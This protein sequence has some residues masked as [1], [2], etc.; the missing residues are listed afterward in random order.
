M[1][2]D[3]DNGGGLD[4]GIDS[5][6]VKQQQQRSEEARKEKEESEEGEPVESTEQTESDESEQ[7][8]PSDEDT[9]TTSTDRD[10]GRDTSAT[11]DQDESS[12]ELP[13]VKEREDRIQAYVPP[14]TFNEFE[15]AVTQIKLTWQQNGDGRKI[16][17]L[18]H[19]YPIILNV[20]TENAE[21]LTADEIG[22]RMNQIEQ[23]DREA[24]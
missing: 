8:S 6:Q 17:K 2:D 23:E 20:G 22:E 3:S 11:S 15:L 14:S 12:D 5:D 13:G 4:L 24:L 16:E 7:S 21:E 10:Q 19:I 1:A 18:R 9:E